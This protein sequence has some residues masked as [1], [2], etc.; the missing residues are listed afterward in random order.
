MLAP[1]EVAPALARP[2]GLG[3]GHIR[4]RRAPV[5]GL[6][7]T[8]LAGSAR[9]KVESFVTSLAK[10]RHAVNTLPASEAVRFC[11]EE[12]GIQKMFESKTEEGRERLNLAAKYENDEPPLGIERLLEEAALQSEQD[13]LDMNKDGGGVTLMTVHAAKGLEI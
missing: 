13:E 9:I 4:Q 8:G 3:G 1:L 11:I 10:I 6:L 7:L 12:S 5:D 2:K